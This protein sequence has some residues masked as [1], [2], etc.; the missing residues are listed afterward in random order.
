MTWRDWIERVSYRCE[1]V[2]DVM[3]RA[4]R[5]DE[6]EDK[7]GQKRLILEELEV[8]VLLSATPVPV[9][10]DRMFAIRWANRPMT[11]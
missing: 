2:I 8:R 3:M 5:S 4:V 10:V 6:G 7:T 1:T 9:E 11:I